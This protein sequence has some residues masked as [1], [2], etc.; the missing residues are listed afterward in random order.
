[1]NTFFNPNILNIKIYI[2]VQGNITGK[3]LEEFLSN[4]HLTDVNEIKSNV[5]FKNLKVNGTVI[6]EN[7]IN[8]SNW[9]NLFKGV[10]MKT[11]QP[12]TVDSLKT[13][14]GLVRVEN[15][16]NIRSG[17]L[18][19]RRVTDFFTVDTDQIL[20]GDTLT[21]D[22]GFEELE[23]DGMFDRVNVTHLNG[24]I[25]TL[26]GDDQN[27]ASDMVFEDDVD[28]SDYPD[29]MDIES[30]TFSFLD[31]SDLV[32]NKYCNNWAVPDDALFYNQESLEFSLPKFKNLYVDHLIVEGSLITDRPI[33]GIDMYEFDRVRLSKTQ[34]K[35]VIAPYTVNN[36]TIGGVDF[37]TFNGLQKYDIVN[38]KN[39]MDNI[40]EELKNGGINVGTLHVKGNLNVTN[41]NGI[42]LRYVADNAIWLKEDNYIGGHLKFVDKMYAK[43]LQLIKNAHGVNFE[44]HMENLV[45]ADDNVTVIIGKKVYSNSLTVLGK[46]TTDFI[47]DFPI[48]NIFTVH[49]SQNLKGNLRV[50]G[51]LSVAKNLQVDGLVD[52]ISMKEVANSFG[53]LKNN[54]YSLKGNFFL[55]NGAYIDDLIIDGLLNDVYVIKDL[56]QSTVNPSDE[57]YFSN[58]VIFTKPVIFKN[59]LNIISTYNNIYI[60]KL[61][62][63]I[64]MVNA[65]TAINSS[66]IFVA[67]V[68][69]KKDLNVENN[70]LCDI[71]QYCSITEWINNAIFLDQYSQISGKYFIFQNMKMIL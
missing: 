48:D 44:K 50:I 46:L 61:L 58:N 2:Q 69:I 68:I 27:L 29:E 33:S 70:M 42:D 47:N 5:I 21:G 52:E 49:N 35:N 40:E 67:P 43:S 10:M 37:V 17:F 34:S 19:N 9:N 14:E 71:V 7:K 8:G 23:V 39:K 18:N 13:F 28:Y 63:D 54:K 45:H 30:R 56:I 57:K 59:N 12:L 51:K 11:N 31:I 20:I 60:Q 64:V 1:M 62:D 41:V 6:V 38:F 65:N 55:D 24:E 26:D 66:I 15:D 3:E 16:L 53:D 36:C 32:V 25:V 22:I 4:P